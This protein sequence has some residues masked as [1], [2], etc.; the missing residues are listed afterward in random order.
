MKLDIQT[1]YVVLILLNIL[2][3]IALAFQYFL[4]KSTRGLSEWVMGTMLVALGFLAGILR[5]LPNLATPAILASNL[6]FVF[7]MCGLY[8]AIKRFL[9]M[10]IRWKLLITLLTAFTI[11]TVYFTLLNDNP[12]ARR[13]LMGLTGSLLSLAVAGSLLHNRAQSVKVTSRF[14]AGVFVIC[15]LIMVCRTASTILYPNQ[16]SELASTPAQ[17]LFYLGILSVTILWSIGFIQMVNQDLQVGI[18]VA[19]TRLETILK[20]SPDAII[21]TRVTSGQIVD[22]N[23]KFE[24]ITGYSLPE[25]IGKSTLE[26]NLYQNP[27]DRNYLIQTI[28]DNG[29]CDQYESVF[30]RKDG[31][32]VHVL[33]SAQVVNLIGEDHIVCIV[34]DISLRIQIEKALRESEEKFR[35]MTENSS[36]VIWHLTSDSVFDY[37]SPADEQIRGYRQD[38]VLGKTIWSQLKPEGVDLLRSANAHRINQEKLGE[39]T[40]IIACEV[41]QRCKDGHWIWTEITIAP[42]RDPEGKLVGYHGVTREITERKKLQDE[43]HKQATTDELTGLFNRRRFL[44]LFHLELRRIER[45]FHPLTILSVDIDRFKKVN[46]HYGHA[47]GDEVLIQFAG[48]L[49]DNIREIDIAARL[50]GDEFVVLFPET[51]SEQAELVAARIMENLVIH[52]VNGLRM[53]RN[54]NISC[55][56]ATLTDKT[57]GLDQILKRADDAL[58]EAK[59]SGRNLIKISGSESTT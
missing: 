39:Q 5:L 38:E 58:Y 26:I 25:V 13:I 10:P 9:L 57:E 49:R 37:I 34:H 59:H 28:I 43:L 55:G 6:F 36:D 54:L 19:K 4:N 15:C 40:G 27:A 29:R 46:D 33:L 44:E 42:Y 1:I 11:A 47:A 23:E 53:P 48:I 14:L 52:P 30:V 12:A 16:L 20:T 2:Q 8:I 56:I 24:I 18:N 21:L 45:H 51:S 31:S 50:G 7:G 32:I 22:V 17:T 35:F 3:T 41:E